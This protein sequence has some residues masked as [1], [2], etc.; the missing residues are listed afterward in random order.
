MN[1]EAVVT[2]A[3]FLGKQSRDTVLVLDAAEDR[4]G[5]IRL[6]LVLEIDPGVQADIDPAR[7]DPYRDMRRL[8]ATVGPGHGTG[9]DGFKAEFAGVHIAG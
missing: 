7:D 8:H 2:V 9:F 5:R 1:V 3:G 6:C 4:I